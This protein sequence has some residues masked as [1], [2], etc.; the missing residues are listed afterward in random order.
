MNDSKS[1]VKQRRPPPL[2]NDLFNDEFTRLLEKTMN[3]VE[4]NDQHA[5][6]QM[7]TTSIE[8]DKSK[9]K[10]FTFENLCWFIASLMCIYFSD[11]T[12]I[13]LYDQSIYRHIMLFAFCLI[14]C[15]VLIAFYLIIYVTY[16]KQINS[17]KWN[18]LYPGLIPVAT[19]CFISGS[20]L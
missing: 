7:S 15:N 6:T 11:I 17:N 4:L 10:S 19:A 2:D 20:I 12:N 14:S 1:E 18:E 9:P 3:K 16:V 5:Q 13:I 8:T